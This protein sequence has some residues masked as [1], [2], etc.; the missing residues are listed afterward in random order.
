M[1]STSSG[2]NKD[3]EYRLLALRAIGELGAGIAIPA[4]LGAFIG[5]QVDARYGVA[6]WGLI[7]CLV[8]GFLITAYMIV[9]TSKKIGEDYKRLDHK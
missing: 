4:V 8:V 3:R 9:K 5:Q 1:V 6:P 7:G 2:P